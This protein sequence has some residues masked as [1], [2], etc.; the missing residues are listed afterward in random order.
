MYKGAKFLKLNETPIETAF[1]YAFGLGGGVGL[2][3]L[4]IVPYLHK[5]AEQTFI[6]EMKDDENHE[7]EIS[8]DKCEPPD[9]TKLHMRIYNFIKNSL[10]MDRR[11]LSKVM[12]LL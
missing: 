1:A 12:K 7:I 8:D 10:N 11:K 4:I 5:L 3:S 9:N 2:L 6:D